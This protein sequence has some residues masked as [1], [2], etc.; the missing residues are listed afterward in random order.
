MSI[1]IIH[2]LDFWSI[3]SVDKIPRGAGFLW[4]NLK[5]MEIATK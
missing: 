1:A 5:Q 2:R 4:Y 3:E